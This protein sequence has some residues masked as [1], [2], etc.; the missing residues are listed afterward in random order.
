MENAMCRKWIE[1]LLQEVFAAVAAVADG[2]VRD[3]N[4]GFVVLNN[5]ELLAIVNCDL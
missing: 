4:T 3:N 2:A 1:Q 5:K